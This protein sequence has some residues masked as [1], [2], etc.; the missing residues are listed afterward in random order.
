[1][2]TL[3][4]IRAKLAAMENRKPTGG[5]S[6]TSI[7]YPFW[8]VNEGETAVVRFLPDGDSSNVFFWRERQVINLPFPGVKGGDQSRPTSVRVPCVEMWGDSCPILAQVRPWWNDKSLEDTA[9]QYWKKRSYLFQALVVEDPLGEKYENENPIRRLIIGPQIFNIV[10]DAL[11][12]PELESNPVDF[13]NGLDFRITVSKKGQYRDYSTSKW[14]RRESAIDEDSIAAIEKHGLFN[15]NDW[16][17]AK[18]SQDHL[19]AMVEM[20]EASVNGDLYDPEK[21]GNFFRPYGLEIDDNDDGDGTT[22]AKPA[23][24]PVATPVK[25]E[26]KVEIKAEEPREKEE[27][28]EG[29]KP[30]TSAQDILAK[31]RNRPK[32]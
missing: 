11:M 7:T 15:L 14:A 5:S 29:G 3:D 19:A 27:V 8:K 23:A 1:M 26:P 6:G 13:V 16:L 32:A 25:E 30:A 28:V 20:F 18:P 2:A 12:D 9:R 21:W 10:K 4:Q 24:T 31:I 17:P 22:A